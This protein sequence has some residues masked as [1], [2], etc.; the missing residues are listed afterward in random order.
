MF[1]Q[2]SHLCLTDH[3]SF[4]PEIDKEVLP[5]KF[6]PIADSE[7]I[8]RKISITQGEDAEDAK[9]DALENSKRPFSGKIVDV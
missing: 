5:S 7:I 4:Q 6:E 1:N 3:F 9:D 2:T 8:K